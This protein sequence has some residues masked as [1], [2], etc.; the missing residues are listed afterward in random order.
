MQLH[1]IAI[2]TAMT[3][4]ICETA[5]LAWT[6]LARAHQAA[7]T[8]VEGALKAADLPPLAWYDILSD[9]ERAGECGLRPFE[10]ERRI[11]LPQYGLS[12][13]LARIEEAGLIDRRSCPGDGRGLLIAITEP[14]RA[15]R[16]RMAPV[17]GAALEEAVGCKLSSEE[18]RGLADLLERLIVTPCE[19][20]AAIG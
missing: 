19:K 15:T 18:A 7:L 8:R 4:P 5:L 20:P 2:L 16:A 14:G 13:L 6:R 3:D 9:L 12:R 1:R 10:L 11:G 17:Y